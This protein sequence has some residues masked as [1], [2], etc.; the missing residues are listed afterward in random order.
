M[1]TK[2]KYHPRS[3]EKAKEVENQ[4]ITKL[5][6]DKL[7][8]LTVWN[9][10]KFGDDV[11]QALSSGKV[12]IF[13]KYVSSRGSVL[14]Q[15]NAKYGEAN[16]AAALATAQGNRATQDIASALQ[17]KQ[18]STWLSK[19]ESLGK[20]FGFLKFRE[21]DGL[22]Q[23]LDT[24][25][26]YLKLF[27][28]KNHQDGTTVF[29]VLRKGFGDDDDQLVLMLS[30]ALRAPGSRPMESTITRYQNL[31]FKEWVTR[32]LDPMSVAVKVFKIPEA[33]V[34]AAK[35]NGEIKSIIKQYSSFFKRETGLGMGPE[36][37]RSGRV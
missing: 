16:V 22:P 5:K 24:L 36:V 12:T 23:K 13:A 35:Y 3:V 17:Q 11:H 28:T 25:Y 4:L 21:S 2:A 14:K 1:I 29:K 19:G 27:K 30:R 18:L 33:N 7:P 6:S 15:L 31:V 10:L 20:V 8:S 34:G 26:E 9:W 37:V 32:D